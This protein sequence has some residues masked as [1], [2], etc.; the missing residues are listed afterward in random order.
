[1]SRTQGKE[2]VKDSKCEDCGNQAKKDCAYSRCRTCCKN[3][4]FQCKTHIR[5]TWIPVDR[6]RQRLE[7]PSPT[8]NP[9][10]SHKHNPYSSLEEFKFP[11]AMNSMTVFNC[12]QVRSMDDSV[13]EMA[14]QTSVNIGGH[15]FSGVLYDQGPEQSFNDARGDSTI[16]QHN[17]NLTSAAIHTRDGATMAPLSATPAHELYFPQPHPFPLSS[18]RPGMPYFS[19]P[20]P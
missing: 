12:V 15:V 19:H 1:M 9:H 10:Q 11:A 13:N 14:Y 3:K 7:Q 20:K 18:F 8:T 4:G 16:H 17:L 2:V 6:R 5:S